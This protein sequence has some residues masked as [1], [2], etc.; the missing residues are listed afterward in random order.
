MERIE[1]LKKDTID[2][3]A[4]GEVVERPASVIKELIENA[5]DAGASAI[6]AEIRE[7]GK[8]L[9]RVTDNGSGIAPDQ[10][11]MAFLRHATSKI[12]SAADL[13]DISSMGFRGEALSSIASVSRVECI[14]K[15]K[16]SLSGIRYVT[17][18]GTFEEMEEIGAP[19]GTTFLVRD[20]FF[21]TPA[22]KK[23]LLSAASE[24]NR[25]RSFAEKMALSHPGIA[26]TF[27]ADGR[28]ILFTSGNGSIPDILY[29]IYG[30]EIARRL[31]PFR[32]ER[33]G[34]RVSGY[35]GTAGTARGNRAGEIFFVNERLIRSEILTKASEEG[36]H[37][38]LMQH[39][40]PFVLLYLQIDGS[41]VDVNVHPAKQEVRF[42]DN[43]ALYLQISQDIRQ[44]LLSGEHIPEASVV[45]SAEKK[46]GMPVPAVPEP[47]E[48][49]R[50]E[51]IPVFSETAAR[52][53]IP[54]FPEKTARKS[55]PA[56]PDP[57]EQ[58]AD[59]VPYPAAVRE[60]AGSY[61]IQQ[62]LFPK[63]EDQ[64]AAS[65]I[66]DAEEPENTLPERVLSKE[67]RRYFRLIGQ[68]FET[69]WLMEYNGS[70]YIVDQHAAHE[71]VLYERLMKQYREKTVTSQMIFPAV[72]IEPG[73]AEAALVRERLP[74]FN[75]LGFEIEEFGGD[76]FKISAVPANIYGAA[77]KEL[78]TD[79]LDQFREEDGGLSGTIAERLAS[80]ACK[81]AVKG[82]M[83]LSVQEAE[84]LFDELLSLENPYHCPHGRPTI[85]TMSREELDKSFKRIL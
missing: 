10:I 29:Q 4:A 42:S 20:L 51:T 57:A 44:T 58:N 65:G 75:D 63:E 16:D 64:E 7:G 49:R 2:Q 46:T 21:N 59:P 26:F 56:F 72:V 45:K 77:Q 71:K 8:K 81:A 40:Y 6:T 39:R 67:A 37:G 66:Q 84:A 17:E 35:L 55:A 62:E 31:I 85:I 14:T 83:L 15:T 18:G 5:V 69:Y 52:E 61:V 34:I 76:S 33:P 73:P 79:I 43:E 78:F 70:L 32:S 48:T 9:I 12:R 82:N 36:Y 25:V 24:G 27:I 74:V 28:T 23:F 13:Q 41:L 53:T 22:R 60:T 68:V 3:I 1:L 54:F 50:R 19:D 47:F 11:D 80:M 38:F 30:K